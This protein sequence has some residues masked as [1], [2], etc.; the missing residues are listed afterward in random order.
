LWPTGLN[1]KSK[2]TRWVPNCFEKSSKELLHTALA[3]FLFGRRIAP[4]FLLVSHRRH[5]RAVCLEPGVTVAMRLAGESLESGNFLRR[6]IRACVGRHA[7][8]DSIQKLEVL[9][10]LLFRSDVD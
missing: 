3:G 6:K 8:I 9:F 1:W 2:A 10:R 4:P 7:L 5:Q